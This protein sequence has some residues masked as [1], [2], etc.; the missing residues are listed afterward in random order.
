MLDMRY[1][2][3]VFLALA[4][5]A[6]MGAPAGCGRAGSSGSSREGGELDSGED[7]G[8]GEP[9]LEDKGTAPG[10]KES[11]S[12]EGEEVM[13]DAE[14]EGESV[15]LTVVYDNNPYLEGLETAW[16]FSCL[17]KGKEKTILFDTGGD[18]DMLLRNM[19]RLGIDP[20]IIDT[21]VISHAHSDHTGGLSRLLRANPGIEVYLPG[22][23]AS[24]LKESVRLSCSRLVEV[25][26]AQQICE[27]VWSTGEMGSG[28]MEQA[29]VIN[30]NAGLLLVT[31]CAHPGVVEL[32]GKAGEVFSQEVYAVMG[33]FHLGSAGSG[34]VEAII[35]GLKALGVHYSGP[36]H[37][38]GDMAT[39]AFRDAFG[40]G[41]I[42]VGVGRRIS[43]AEISP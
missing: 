29:L 14:G 4:L 19:S 9:L 17:V 2:A 27:G 16:G 23:C 18:G 10:E 20:G 12:E 36:C 37:C 26:G 43:S 22:S 15:V 3:C 34:E 32:A 6:S 30:S 11:V 42:Q 39:R 13:P 25:S 31:G 33:G 1:L 40:S 7:S 8:E 21:V 28:V 41:F 5:I 35:S 38:T 24:G